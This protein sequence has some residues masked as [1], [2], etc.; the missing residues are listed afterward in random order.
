MIQISFEESKDS[1]L[2]LQLEESKSATKGS[3]EIRRIRGQQLAKQ[4]KWR[5]PHW[6]RKKNP[7]KGRETGRSEK[8]ARGIKKK[9][10]CLWQLEGRQRKKQKI[11]GREREGRKEAAK[12]P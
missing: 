9:D 4:R 8:K 10:S 1:K 5:S 7:K 3:K 2:P 12:L 11:I 6:G